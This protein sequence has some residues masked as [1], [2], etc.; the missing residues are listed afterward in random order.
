MARFKM[1]QSFWTGQQKVSAG[2]VLVD[3]QANAQPGDVVYT[4]LNSTNIPAGAIAL[5]ASAS[6]MLAASPWAGVPLACCIL[7]MDSIA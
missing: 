2:H 4:A 6:A 3:T 5:D 1:S 7:G